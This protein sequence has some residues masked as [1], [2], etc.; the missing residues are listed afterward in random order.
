MTGRWSSSIVW[1][2]VRTPIALVAVVSMLAVHLAAD[3][4]I[5]GWVGRPENE[6]LLLA[7]VAVPLAQ[8]SLLALWA[9]AGRGRSY[10]RAL[11]LAFGPA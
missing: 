4:L 7:A 2:M 11:V 3:V 10:V 5:L 1:G 9:A 8:A 6:T